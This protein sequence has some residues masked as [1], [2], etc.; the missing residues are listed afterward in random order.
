MLPEGNRSLP[1]D[2]SGALFSQNFSGT[3]LSKLLPI[4]NEGY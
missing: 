1:I 2:G 4:H 3:E